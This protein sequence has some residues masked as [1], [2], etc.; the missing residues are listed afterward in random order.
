M[1]LYDRARHAAIEPPPWSEAEAREAIASVFADAEDT[2]HPDRYWPRHPDD[3]DG[4]G[5]GPYFD[6]YFG[7]AGVMWGLEKLENLGYGVVANDYEA[8]LIAGRVRHLQELAQ[9][10]DASRF[11]GADKDDYLRGLFL[12]DAGFQV[13]LYGM[14]ND[15]VYL[16]RLYELVASNV[17]NPICE[18]MWGSPGTLAAALGCFERTGDA[19]WREIYRTGID[20]LRSMLVEDVDGI[21][22]WQQSIYGGEQRFLG[23][24]H[25]FAGNAFA[26]IKGLEHLD[27]GHAEDWAALIRTTAVQTARG[28]S[29]LANWSAIHGAPSGPDPGLVVQHCHGAPGIITTLGALMDGTD[30]TFDQLMIQGGDLVWQAGPLAKGANLCHGTAGNG[31]AFLK[32]Y[33]QTRDA[34]WLDRARAFGM[35]AIEQMR[36]RRQE[37]GQARYSLWTGDIGTALYLDGCIRETADVPTMDVFF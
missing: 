3:A 10:L 28:E 35:A 6:L 2:F 5:E 25:G 8:P 37:T 20:A 9:F 13:V 7:A 27:S 18:Y 11:P 29:E 21:R 24:V 23:A 33:R 31:Y 4:P 17:N 14:T 32:L 12:G 1:S 15:S 16:D 30:P 26:I 36:A 34:L 19:R 22:L